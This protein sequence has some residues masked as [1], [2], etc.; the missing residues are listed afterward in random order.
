MSDCGVC[1]GGGD[2]DGTPEFSHISTP[3][4]RKDHKCLECRRAIR[5]GSQ[6]ERTSGKFDGNIYSDAVCL[7]CAEIRDAFY[8]GEGAYIVGDLWEQMGEC[9]PALTTGCFDRLTTPAAKAFLRDRWLKWKG[10]A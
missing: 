3:K 6:Y 10:L 5:R 7:E 1:I 2:Y 9:F 4:A 8:C